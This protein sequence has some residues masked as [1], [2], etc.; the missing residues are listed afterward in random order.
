MRTASGRILGLILWWTTLAPGTA[1]A[2]GPDGTLLPLRDLVAALERRTSV[3]FELAQP[4]FGDLLVAGRVDGQPLDQ[5]LRTML[6][7][8]SYVIDQGPGRSVVHVISRAGARDQV[9]APQAADPPPPTR[10]HAARLQQLLSELAFAFADTR[11]ETLNELVGV[12]DGRATAALVDETRADRP[13]GRIEAVR[14]LWRH[15]ASLGF[16]DLASAGALED[17]AWDPDDTVASI[18]RS[19]LDDLHAFRRSAPQTP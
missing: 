7:D 19:A 2:A 6:R 15:A 9:A 17:L 11:E 18:A 1:V 4:A 3:R 8:F 14:R 13:A 16:A 10:S 5:A 12:H